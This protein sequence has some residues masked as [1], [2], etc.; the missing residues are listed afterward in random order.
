MKPRIYKKRFI[1]MNKVERLQER[2]MIRPF[3]KDNTF[4]KKKREPIDPPIVASTDVPKQSRPKTIHIFNRPIHREKSKP[5]GPLK[6]TAYQTMLEKA[7]QIRINWRKKREAIQAK[8]IKS[9]SVP[10]QTNS[11][12]RSKI[13]EIKIRWKKKGATMD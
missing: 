12:Q 9:P 7:E 8:Q 4:D 1:D 10:K 6:K 3:F 2:R 13:E 11:P 5:V